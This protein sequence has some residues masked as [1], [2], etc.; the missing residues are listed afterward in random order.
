MRPGQP[1]RLL[2]EAGLP[3]AVMDEI[4]RQRHPVLRKAVRDALAGRP[5]RALA[6]LGER[7]EEVEPQALAE[8]AA[9]ELLALA[10][11]ARAHTLVVAPTNALRRDINAAVRDG[12]IAEGVVHGGALVLE[13]LIDLRLTGPEKANPANYQ[14][15]DEVVFVQD[16]LHY[17]VRSGEACLVTGVEGARVRLRHPEGTAR[18]IDPRGPVRHQ[19]KVCESAPIEIRAGDRIRWTHNDKARGLLNGETARIERIGRAGVTLCTADGRTLRLASHDR[20]L[21]HIDHAYASTAHAAQGATCER[22]IAVLDADPMPLTNQLTFYVQISRARAEVTVLTDDGERL[23]E[24][25]EAQSGE[26]ESAH[27]ALG[28][29]PGPGDAAAWARRRGYER[30]RRDWRRVRRRAR[31]RLAPAVEAQAYAGVRRQVEALAGESALPAYMRRFVDEWLGEDRACEARERALGEV[32]DGAARLERPGGGGAAPEDAEE[33]VAGAPGEAPWGVP[34][35]DLLARARRIRDD[36]GA[37]GAHLEALEGG[38]E[39]FDRAQ[40]GL[41]ARAW[42]ATDAAVA[43]EASETG[44]MAFYAPGYE[45]DAREHTE[46]ARRVLESSDDPLHQRLGELPALQMHFSENLETLD[47]C[48]RRDEREREKRRARIRSQSRDSGVER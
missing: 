25:L 24:T 12:L 6:Y 33:T 42:R 32:L 45:S 41:E 18:H 43:R 34:E 27:E 11:E 31:G 44:T 19:V 15:G 9:H 1:F 23:I 10:P 35:R 47:E 13:R 21:R 28:W 36:P 8:R 7:L 40:A 5:A 48:H 20:Q 22:V 37:Y 38:R 29:T 3:T 39:R 16:L 2:Q 14:A 17:R 30:V 4:V 26:R 46:V